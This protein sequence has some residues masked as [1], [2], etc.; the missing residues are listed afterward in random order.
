MVLK[1]LFFAILLVASFGHAKTLIVTD[2]DDTIKASHVRNKVDSAANAFVTTIAFK[3]I[4]EVYTRV[5]EDTDA[6]I[7]YVTN[8][9]EALMSNSHGDFIKKNKF[10]A[11]KIYLRKGHADYHK[12]NSIRNH[13]NN[14]TSIDRLIM[15]GD[16]GERDIKFYEEIAKEYKDRLMTIN[17]YI[18][19]VYSEPYKVLPLAEGQKGFVSPLEL[20]ADLTVNQFVRIDQYYPLAEELSKEIIAAKK[21]VTKAPH[22]FPD[23]LTC[24]NFEPGDYKALM[25]PVIAEG[26]EKVRSICT[27]RF[28]FRFGPI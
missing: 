28:K 27:P 7:I 8:A 16:N 13:L 4:S 15:V 3:G 1:S 25:T 22:Y 2:I 12:L 14:D 9:P 6:E 21:V 24:K 10:P 19:I 17:T 5:L 23:W 18:R 20:L 11:G 26:F